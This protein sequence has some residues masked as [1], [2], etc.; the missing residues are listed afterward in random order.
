MNNNLKP[1]GFYV[2]MIQEGGTWKVRY[3]FT[4]RCVRSARGYKGYTSSIYAHLLSYALD[5]ARRHQSDLFVHNP[6]GTVKR[7]FRF[8]PSRMVESK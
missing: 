1:L 6:D 8:V 7:A 5:F 2:H 4:G 3:G